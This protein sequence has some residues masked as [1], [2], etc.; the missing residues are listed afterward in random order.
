MSRCYGTL[1]QLTNHLFRHLSSV[2][3][4]YMIHMSTLFITL[5]VTLVTP[6]LLLASVNIVVEYI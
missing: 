5:G 3:I 4:V 6:Y 1:D 2:R